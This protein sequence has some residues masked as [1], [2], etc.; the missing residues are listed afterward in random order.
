MPAEAPN[1]VEPA[2]IAPP[3]ARSRWAALWRQAI[4][5]LLEPRVLVGI[6][7]GLS[8]LLWL[9]SLADWREVVALA[10]RLP[11]WLLLLPLPAHLFGSA[12]RVARW[13]IML[14]AGGVRVPWRRAAAAWFGA[15]LLGPLPASPLF[16]S[17]LLHRG[18][19]PAASTLPVV[20]AGLWVDVAVVVGG[21][22]LVPGVVPAPVRL[23]AA[24]LWLGCLL[25]A[26]LLRQAP[27][28]R[29][30]AAASTWLAGRGRRH[31]R[32]GDTWWRRLERL[33]GW[34]RLAR[35]AFSPAA[36][37]PAIGLTLVPVA[38]GSAVS[39]AQ[40]AALGY[41]Q[42]TPWRVWSATGVVMVLGLLS[43]LPFDLGVAEGSSV[44]AW[45]W[46]GVP[47]A[48]A[49]AIGLLGRAWSTTL[50]LLLAA[51]ATWL[52]RAELA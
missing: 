33:P 48:A 40:A 42:M 1:T 30:F 12:C 44:L 6:G 51:T 9:T 47:P 18:G 17:Y 43:P 49:L 14:R 46:S 19:A 34:V 45:S 27:L 2:A 29:L 25:G 5:G 4:V 41:P 35:A 26:L 3:A 37:L 21:T 23:A 15:D 11:P 28:Y 16:A 52:L 8:L 20:L 13:L 38:L 32:R 31:W 36:L 7:A 24:G 10:N 22:A 50:G 39:A